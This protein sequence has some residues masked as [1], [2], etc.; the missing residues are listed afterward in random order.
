MDAKRLDLVVRSLFAPQSRRTVLSLALSGISRAPFLDE[1]GAKKRR[2]NKKKRK[3]PPAPRCGACAD[4]EECVDQRCVSLARICG[5]EDDGCFSENIVDCGEANDPMEE[6]ARCQ[7]TLGGNPVCV[8][9]RSTWCRPC[10]L[11]DDCERQGWGPRGVCL[12]TCRGHCGEGGPPRCA[13]PY[14]EPC[15]AP[16]E[17]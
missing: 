4:N 6:R 13:L 17:P 10:T 3:K 7:L 9:V 14:G 8:R 5:V 1:A 15:R 16:G 11:H 2:K 12:T